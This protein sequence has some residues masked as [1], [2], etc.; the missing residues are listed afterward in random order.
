MPEPGA[1]GAGGTGATT[2]SQSERALVE[3]VLWDA[4]FRDALATRYVADDP[5]GVGDVNEDYRSKEY[6]RIE[7][8]T[9][10]GVAA[11]AEQLQFT[12]SAPP[13]EPA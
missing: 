3:V 1:R 5:F 8:V 6:L 13:T 11:S 10:G 4:A 12:P 7:Q 9:V 2:I